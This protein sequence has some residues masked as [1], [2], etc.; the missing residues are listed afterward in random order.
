MTFTYKRRPSDGG[1]EEIRFLIQDT[2][3]SS[4]F[5]EDEEITYL[6]AEQVDGNVNAIC[7]A[8][9]EI[10]ASKY[11]KKQEFSVSNYNQSLDN[12]YKKL[13]S[14]AKDFRD[15]AVTTAHFKVPSISVSS[16]Q[17]Q[18]VDVD[19]VKASFSRDLLDNPE[20]DSPDSK[21]EVLG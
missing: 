19:N 3:D 14:R 1:I 18:V 9:F 16:K 17:N 13:M 2:E 12:V 11:A 15:N 6:I 5:L 20:A 10:M 7:A 21:S 4:H 8:A